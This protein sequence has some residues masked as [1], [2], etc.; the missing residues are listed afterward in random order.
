MKTIYDPC[1]VGYMLPAARAFTGFTSAGDNS[2]DATTFN[3][4]GSFA[5]GWKFKRN[6]AD[7]QGNFFPASGC[8]ALGSGSLA[9]MGSGGY[10]WS[11]AGNSQ[12]YAR[13]LYFYSGYVH[14]LNNFNRSYGFSVRPCREFV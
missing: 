8:R 6:S 13:Y 14:P 1:P 12:A 7:A 4:V 10:Y 3:V 2:S 5:Q 9:G 11:F